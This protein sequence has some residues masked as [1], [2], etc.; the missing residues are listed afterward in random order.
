MVCR[1]CTHEEYLG[2]VSD[3]TG[4]M[5]RHAVIKATARDVAAV[6]RCRE[7]EFLSHSLSIS[8]AHLKQ[9]LL[10][11]YCFA[12]VLQTRLCRP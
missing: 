1:S 8:R 10:T 12:I 5:Q 7:C 11:H 2:G 3:L 4:E 9:E 6:R